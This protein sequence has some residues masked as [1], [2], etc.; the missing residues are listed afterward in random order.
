MWLGLCGVRYREWHIPVP[1]RP[2]HP[3]EFIGHGDC[4]LVVAMP[5][6]HRDGPV[7]QP[8]ERLRGRPATRGRH[9]HRAGAVG[10]QAPE[11]YVPAFA[12]PPEAPPP[13]ARMPAAAAWRGGHFAGRRAPSSGRCHTLPSRRAA[14]TSRRESGR[15][16]PDSI[17]GV[18]GCAIAHRP[19]PAQK[20]SLRGQRPPS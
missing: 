12:D 18:G 13:A 5:V 9:E 14:A 1:N 19:E 17:A 6:A 20:R 16:L 4:G 15:T 10:E 2:D 3:P 7:M 8:C 11:I